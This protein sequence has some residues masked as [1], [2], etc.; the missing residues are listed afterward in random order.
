MC[1]C[2]RVQFF[3]IP[4]RDKD[5]YIYGIITSATF[6]NARST[7][8]L[9]TT[10]LLCVC[11]MPV[12]R[13]T[14]LLLALLLCACVYLLS[15]RYSSFFFYLIRSSFF[16]PSLVAFFFCIRF[17]FIFSFALVVVGARIA[18]ASTQLLL[19]IAN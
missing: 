12:A 19:S 16:I 2:V 13:A 18:P 14:F 6:V 4:G 1:P 3:F 10:T 7:Y 17:F 15:L 11:V 8:I 9:S 5:W